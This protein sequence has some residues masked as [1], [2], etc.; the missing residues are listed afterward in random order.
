MHGTLL[1]ISGDR[2]VIRNNA[3]PATLPS[4][5][6]VYRL[7]PN[8]A[9]PAGS[10]I[11]GLIDRSTSPWTLRRALIAAAFSPGMP[12]AARVEAVDVGSKL[13][14]A[15]LVDQTGRPLDLATA[16]AG[17]TV[18]LSFV[19]TR[20]PDRNL[21]PAISGK[22]A[23]LQGHL[24]PSKFAL[25]EIT[26][27]PPYDSPAILSRY[28]AQFG[29]KRGSWYFL[30]GTPTTIQR[31]LNEFHI[32][33]LRV[34]AANFIHN[35]KLYIVTPSGRIAYVVDTAGWDP[36][37]VASEA[38]AVA[39][40]ASNPLERFKL[41]LIASVVALCGGSQYAGIVFLELALFAIVVVA[42]T[43]G[44]WTVGRVL[45]KS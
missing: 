2:A 29:A 21:C 20:C 7:S 28:G 31:V 24:D 44:L 33:S 4:V 39:G 14:Q 35:D 34:S 3:I 26:L 9:A 45:W 8:V 27:D 1:G 11:E 18:L 17:K 12:D 19:F 37:G 38:S 32:N 40:M 23:Y 42:V 6:R 25:V 5:T 41:S 15:Q 30:T 16:F 13:P 36:D 10:G 43:A 22:Y